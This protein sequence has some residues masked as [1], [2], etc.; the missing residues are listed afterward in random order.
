MRRAALFILFLMF[1][2]PVLAAD[3]LAT[4]Q[5]HNSPEV[6]TREAALDELFAELKQVRS[7]SEAAAVQARIWDVWMQSGSPTIDLLMTRSVE[8]MEGGDLPHA[9]VLLN[10]MVELAPD[11]PEGWNKRATVLYYL[12]EW[13]LS[14]A[15]IAQT[16]SREPRH[17]GALSGL[18]MIFDDRGDII[19]AEIARAQIHALMPLVNIVET[20]TESP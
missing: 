8:A 19:Q 7:E 14:L 10:E 3:S 9:L 12:G 4:H 15:D 18:A 17:F 2:L 1:A 13:R 20:S 16:L 5:P 6:I 11:Y